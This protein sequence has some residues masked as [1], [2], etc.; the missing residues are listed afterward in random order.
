MPA[1]LAEG[2]RSP[3]Q[4]AR[5]VSEAWA[6][7]NL[8]CPCCPSPHLKLFDPNAR[9]VDLFCPTCRAPFQLKSQSRP[10]SA[11]VMDAGYDAMV[12]AIERGNTPHLFVLDYDRTRWAARNLVLIPRFA[13]SLSCV[14][15]RRP[16]GPGAR[17]SGWVGCNILLTNIPLDARIPVIT[18]GAPEAPSRVRELF[19][20]LRPLEKSGQ[21][22]RGWTLDVLRVV[23]S[24]HAERFSL[25][26]VY[27]GEDEL[28]KLH[29]RNRNVRPKIRQ[30]L[31][32]LRD[33]GLVEFLGNGSYRV[34][35]AAHRLLVE[36]TPV[37]PGH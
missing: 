28:Q 36:G 27:D 22:A 35:L 3:S 8:F 12:E 11:R 26:D 7:Q 37:P 34:S 17:R 32:R 14:E 24:L 10:V 1:H 31:Q 13:F 20:R 18:A 19:A 25:A 29:P 23:R 33:M 5:V 2:Y 30:Q 16:L 4:R 6:E 21:E 9:A 15:K